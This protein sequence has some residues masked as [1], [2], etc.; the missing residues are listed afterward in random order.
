MA[1]VT[2]EGHVLAVVAYGKDDLRVEERPA[3]VPG[4]SEALVDIAYGGICGSDLHYWRHGAA[5]ES[6]IRAPLVLGHEFVGTVR[7]A[8][9]DGTGPPAG[10]RVAVH[11][12]LRAEVAS[13][14][15]PAHRP[16]IEPGGGY[17]GSAARFPHADGGFAS[18]VSI[19]AGMLRVLPDSLSFRLAILAEPV[20]VAWHAVSRAGEVQGKRVLVVG[21]GPIGALII[22][23]LK[24]RGAAEII[25]VD[26]VEQP[27]R[28]A[29]EVGATGTIFATESQAIASADA[30]VV[31]E[32]SG[33][34]RGLASAVR[35]ATRG[36]RV[37][38][39]GLLPAG[40]Q[41]ALM[42]LVIT[43]ELELT[44]SFR[45]A[46]EMDDVIAALAE[47]SLYVSPVITHEFAVDDALAA[48]RVASDPAVSSKVLL[49]FPPPS[50]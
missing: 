23:V 40:E 38:L 1:M 26:T 13:G 36:G 42:S 8:A 29:T 11:P 28:I 21:C 37:V 27:L 20:S 43:R 25:A 10:A 3:P 34:Y 33:N 12:A 7:A 46:D 31:I 5:G 30:D 4:D 9:A 39:V 16:N 6:V 17:L 41:P 19:A 35:G 24:H 48:F 44:G 32:S 15:F 47:G 14:R 18:R 50:T 22:A 2:A 49:R 45:F